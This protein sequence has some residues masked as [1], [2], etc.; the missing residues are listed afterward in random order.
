MCGDVADEC[1]T[2]I[3]RSLQRNV[4]LRFAVAD[5]Y[6][7]VYKGHR[8]ILLCKY[9]R[10]PSKIG[11]RFAKKSS[12]AR[13]LPGSSTGDDLPCAYTLTEAS[14]SIEKFRRPRDF[15]LIGILQILASGRVEWGN[16][17][18]NGLKTE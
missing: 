7:R 14:L 9:R 13:S 5:T 18:E 8:H 17:I 10:N 3:D 16:S 11:P 6:V 12:L 2:S 15:A 4:Y 1:Y